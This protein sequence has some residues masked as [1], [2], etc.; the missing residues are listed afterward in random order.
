[1]TRVAAFLYRRFQG[2]PARQRQHGLRILT[3]AV[4]V[5]AGVAGIALLTFRGKTNGER[6]SVARLERVTVAPGAGLRAGE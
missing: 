6:E 1:M 3:F 2:I 5:W 4:A